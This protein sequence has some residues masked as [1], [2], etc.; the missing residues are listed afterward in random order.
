MNEITQLM[1]QFGFPVAVAVYLLTRL[2][3]RMDEF[4]K[5]TNQLTQTVISMRDLL[6]STL[7]RSAEQ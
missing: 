4:T 3:K 2:D 5:A 6:S 1:S 7:S